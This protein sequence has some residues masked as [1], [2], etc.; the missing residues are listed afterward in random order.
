M[1]EGNSALRDPTSLRQ[2][3]TKPGWLAR[4]SLVELGS[5]VLLCQP[6]PPECQNLCSPPDQTVRKTQFLHHQ[7]EILQ[8]V[9]Q[10]RQ[11]ASGHFNTASCI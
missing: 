5:A 4:L 11:S 1:Q 3:A 8:F 6:P 2:K 7:R 10:N 9:L